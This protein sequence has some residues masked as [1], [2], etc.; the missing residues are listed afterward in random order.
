MA[1]GSRKSSRKGSRKGSKKCPPG[2]I[3]RKSYT[4]KSHVRKSRGRGQSRVKGSHVKKTKVP[5]TCV[6]DR[7][8]PGKGPKTLPKFSGKLKLTRYGYSTDKSASARHDALVKA[9]KKNNPLEVLRHLNLLR[10]YQADD[11]KGRKIAK[12]MGEDVKFMSKYYKNWK[13]GSGMKVSRKS[14]KSSKKGSKK[15]S[16][17]RKSRKSSKKGTK[18][19]SR[20]RK[21]SKKRSRKSRSRK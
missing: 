13:R 12:I 20:S 4:R 6:K 7:G 8:K 17:S 9:S 19:R 1:K 11:P 16:R 15:G 2:K 21:S 18:K 3:L 14:R 5:A 10:N